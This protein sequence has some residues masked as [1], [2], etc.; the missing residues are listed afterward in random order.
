[1]IAVFLVVVLLVVGAIHWYVWKRLVKD[2]TVTKRGR[3][4]GTAIMVALGL[5]VPA[6]LIGS[7]TLPRSG[8]AILAWP[9]FL[10]LALMFYLLVTLLILELPRLALRAWS[11]RAP[12]TAFAMEAVPSSETVPSAPPEPAAEPS[13]D[14][15]RRLLLGRSVAVAAGALS[16]GAVGIG[17]G[18]AMSAPNL[19]RVP[20]RL[21]KLPAGMDGFKIALVSDIHLGPLLG[22]SHTE[23]IVRMINSVDADLVAIVGDL[24]DGSVAELGAAAEPLQDLRGKHGSFFV[25]G[26]HEYFSGYQEWVDEVNSLGVRVLRNERIDIQGFDLAG[27]NDLSGEGVGDGP[28]FTKA[29]DGRDRGRPVILLAHQPIQAH[30]AAKHGVDLQLSGH[31]HGGQMVPFNLLVGLQ[32]PVVAGLGS[33]DGTQVYVTRGAGFWGPPVRFGAPPDI[34]IIE[35]HGA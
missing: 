33:V 13:F 19:K 2:T 15:G 27:V 28:D 23:R 17:T 34:S 22:R 25:T 5:L 14:P 35:L 6:T 11:R 30:E 12:V 16:A 26:N 32:Q 21:A 18:Q 24:V 3:R 31:T 1:V 10:W 7:R 8:E 9:G 4:T 29:L 20:I